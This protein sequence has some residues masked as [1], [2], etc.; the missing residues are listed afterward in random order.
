MVETRACA[1]LDAAAAARLR[2]FCPSA[3]ASANVGGGVDV[4]GNR[5]G[6]PP[7]APTENSQRVNTIVGCLSNNT[8]LFPPSK[9][10]P[11]RTYH[12]YARETATNANTCFFVACSSHSLSTV[13]LRVDWP[14]SPGYTL[15]LRRGMLQGWSEKFKFVRRQLWIT[16]HKSCTKAKKKKKKP[17]K[18]SISPAS[19]FQ[20]DLSLWSKTLCTFTTN[21][22]VKQ[23]IVVCTLRQTPRL[24]KGV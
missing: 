21:T 13:P 20:Q 11:Q 6:L 9:N 24:G 19:S 15:F 12:G 10:K 14:L 2:S 16:F 23:G 8:F 17:K 4:A 1:E 3:S 22:F 18:N 7:I 5:S